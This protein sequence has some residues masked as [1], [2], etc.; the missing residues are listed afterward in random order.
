MA[1]N[2]KHGGDDQVKRKLLL[3][4]SG[5][6]LA[7]VASN[8]ALATP[9]VDTI[10]DSTVLADSGDATQTQFVADSLGTDAS[11]LDPTTKVGGSGGEDG[12]WSGSGDIWSFDLGW[13]WKLAVIKLGAGVYLDGV[14]V[15]TLLLENANP[16]DTL[17]TL[18]LGSFTR[19]RGQMT[20][21]VV[22]GISVPE[23]GALILFGSG[24]LGLGLSGWRRRK[25][26]A[27]S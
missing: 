21:G 11:L 26:R 1:E 4:V 3:V 18:D 20:I 12:G 6:G 14:L 10:L 13:V 27:S 17:V 19:D 22:S 5:L 15:N 2:N 24:L 16:L 8:A 25:A 9:I 7:F 23:P